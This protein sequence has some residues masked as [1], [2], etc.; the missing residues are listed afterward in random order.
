MRYT[1]G[2]VKIHRKILSY[3]WSSVLDIQA[4]G[5][6]LQLICMANYKPSKLLT[7]KKH[8]ITLQPGQIVT[9]LR[10]LAQ[11]LD[12][13]IKVISTRLDILEKLGTIT[14]KR[15]HS[16]TLITIVNYCKYQ[17]DDRKVGNTQG[18]TEGNSEGYTEGNTEGIHIKKV[19][20]E[21]KL[22]KGKETRARVDS[23]EVN[24]FLDQYLEMMTQKYNV[25]PMLT[26][27]MRLNASKIVSVAS[28]DAWKTVLNAYLGSERKWHVSRL[29]DLQT[30]LDDLP[31]IG[32]AC[33]IEI[34]K[35]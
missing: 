17:G 12:T 19:K 15:E 35:K 26:E 29:H 14:Q 21:K 3:E 13:S 4:K 27:K 18:N 5:L 8:L 25:R 1:S 33:G 11:D 22:N 28:G 9:S 23:P 34:N 30:L 10:E 7:R 20:N 6:L 2:W 32:I 16:G 31:S 24:D